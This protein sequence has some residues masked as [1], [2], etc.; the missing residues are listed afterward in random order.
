MAKIETKK[1]EIML[2]QAYLQETEEL[3]EFLENV[4]VAGQQEFLNFVRGANFTRR[5]LEGN[6]KQAV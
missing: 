3:Q 5:L 2:P 1:V 6:V 4:T